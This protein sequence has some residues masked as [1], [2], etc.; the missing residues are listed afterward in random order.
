MGGV[1]VGA[2]VLG[3][4]AITLGVW[5]ARG[6]AADDWERPLLLWLNPDRP[7]PGLD[8]LVVLV[9]DFATP[10]LGV[11]L[12]G[13]AVGYQ[14]QVRGRVSAA[15]LRAASRVAGVV[16]GA[17][18]AGTVAVA[19]G[20]A[21]PAGAALSALAAFA[22][23]TWLGASYGRLDAER[24][25]A[26]YRTGWLALAAVLLSELARELLDEVAARPRPLADA[27]AAWNA[28]L[29]V[30]PE[31]RASRG[32][33]YVSGHAST[34]FALLTPFFW[35]A[36]SRSVRTALIALA[37]GVSL[38]RLYVAA[39]FPLCVAM[40]GVLGFAMGTLVF[41]AAPSPSG[42]AADAEP[43]GPRVGSE[44]ASSG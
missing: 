10:L 17:A 12:V 42:D 29:R 32:S 22:L 39:H 5:L 36:R 31:E 25:A 3:Y 7:V 20:H 15:R 30:L 16:V 24:L 6:A 35:C 27:N 2:L 11:C 34:I 21:N 44:P 43:R 13:W 4:A 14:L 26:W 8:A 1:R 41:R 28:A 37:L 40:G 18:L 19:E 23:V 38:T 33:S 9:T